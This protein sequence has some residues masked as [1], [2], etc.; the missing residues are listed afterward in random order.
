MK[1]I[2]LLKFRNISIRPRLLKAIQYSPLVAA[3]IAETRYQ[4]WQGV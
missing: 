1:N 3:G 4:I 2:I